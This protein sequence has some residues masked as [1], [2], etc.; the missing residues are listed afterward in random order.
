MTGDLMGVGGRLTSGPTDIGE[1]DQTT[2]TIE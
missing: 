2:G 1:R